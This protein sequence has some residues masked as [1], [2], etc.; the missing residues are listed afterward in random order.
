MCAMHLSHKSFATENQ[1]SKA[2]NAGKEIL[3]QINDAK[4]EINIISNASIDEE[5]FSALIKSLDKQVSVNLISNF[6]PMNIRQASQELN[7]AEKGANVKIYTSEPTISNSSL[8]VIDSTFFM[9]DFQEVS[10]EKNKI[11]ISE[12]VTNK[13]IAN[14]YSELIKQEMNKQFGKCKLIAK[15]SIKYSAISGTIQIKLKGS[16]EAETDQINKCCCYFL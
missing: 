1:S 16:C 13:E 4:T 15:K 5:V 3:K 8:I 2:Q 14:S 12:M 9:H 10:K 7:L 11:T 6:D